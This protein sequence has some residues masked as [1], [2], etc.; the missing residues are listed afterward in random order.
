MYL[1]KA[2]QK[3]ATSLGQAQMTYKENV[4][5][6]NTLVTNVLASKLPTL[7]EYPPDWGEFT[8]AYLAATGAA[9][10]WVNDVMARLLY[11][12][13][14]IQGYNTI[15]STLLQ[16]AT[17][18]AQTLVTQ[19]TNAQALAI[20]TE[21]LTNLSQQLN[22]IT[23]FIS[24]AITNIQKFKDQLPNMATQLQTIA[25]KSIKDSQADQAQITQ[26]NADI[27]NL[28]DDISSLTAAIVG[29]AIADGIALTI[30]VVAT[31]AL[32]PVGALVWFALGPAVAVATTFIALDAI[33]I[34][35]DKAAIEAKQQLITGITADVATLSILAN[36][37]SAMAT[38]AE[39]I[40]TNL[41]AILVEWQTLETDVNTAV[42]DIVKAG[43]SKDA[44]AFSDVVTDLNAA[45]TEWTAAYNQAGELN[46]QINVNTAQLQYGMSSSEVQTALAGGQTMDIITYYNTLG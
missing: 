1:A 19:P 6:V 27:A 4:V 11:V 34:K 2:I 15:I 25:A 16:N 45:A 42:A 32:W 17:N 33:Q 35:N 43:Q 29:L 20:L 21:D 41:Q 13:A 7:N 18:Q 46:I 24:G 38:Q 5:T 26:L 10:N 39:A 31:I 30:G 44:S 12:P 23:T 9:L 37:Y 8:E 14:E 28:N 22:I 40:E 3:N 36:S